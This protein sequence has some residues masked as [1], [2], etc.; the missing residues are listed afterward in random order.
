MN[1]G[2]EKQKQAPSRHILQYVKWRVDGTHPGR[3]SG[4]GWRRS[5][6]SG[7]RSGDHGVWRQTTFSAPAFSPLI[8]R[9]LGEGGLR[10]AACASLGTRLRSACSLPYWSR[11]PARGGYASLLVLTSPM[12]ISFSPPIIPQTIRRRNYHR[13]LQSAGVVKTIVCKL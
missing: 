1:L 3:Q 4:I 6:I 10:A 11:T 7:R 9:S 13:T 5:E 8:R 12:R 2:L